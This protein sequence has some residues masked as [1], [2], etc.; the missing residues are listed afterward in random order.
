MGSAGPGGAE[1]KQASW[2][3]GRHAATSQRLNAERDTND[4]L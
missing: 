1:E 2:F 4:I 3:A